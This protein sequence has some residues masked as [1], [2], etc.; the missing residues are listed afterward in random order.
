MRGGLAYKRPLGCEGFALM[1]S[2]KIAFFPIF[3]WSPQPR[4]HLLVLPYYAAL[5]AANGSGEHDLP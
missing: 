2:E 3:G 5:K 1:V 4:T